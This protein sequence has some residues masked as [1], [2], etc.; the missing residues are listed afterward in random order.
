MGE[1]MAAVPHRPDWASAPPRLFFGAASRH[2]GRMHRLLRARARAAVFLSLVLLGLGACRSGTPGLA[3]ATPVGPAPAAPATAPPPEPAPAPA[4]PLLVAVPAPMPAAQEPAPTE[5][6]APEE[7]PASEPERIQ[8]EALEACQSAEE[9]LGR[10][11]VDAALGAVDR[12]YALMLELPGNHDDTY[13]QAKEDIRVLAASLIDRIYAAGR[14]A[15]VGTARSW[16]LALPIVDNEHVQREL[17]SFTTVERDQFL[18]GYRRSGLY[19]PMILARLEKAGLPAQLSW[20]P[21]VESW[22]KVRALSRAS[23]LGMWQFISST[24]VRYGLDRDTWVDERLDPEKST[25]AAIGYL[26]DLHGLFGD[27]PKA[28][29]AY[30]CGEARVLRLSR[31]S[32]DEYLDFWDLYETLPGETRRYVPRLLAALLIIENP[33]KYGMTLP[34]PD[35]APTN[36]AT[37]RVERSVRLDRLDAALELDAGTLAGLNPALRRQAT[38]KRAYDLR[39]PEGREEALLAQLGSVPEWTPPAPQYATHRVRSG[40]TL[41]QIAGHYGTSVSALMRAN[42]LRSS[43]LRVGQRLRV[44]VRG[45]AAAGGS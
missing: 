5:E 44:P 30:N 43:R 14:H 3:P 29:A 13:L 45:A 38:P 34:E 8:K 12:A 33:A 10:G 42:G 7:E 1:L 19:R 32:T 4:P 41:S 24:G 23:A 27:W 37:V 39:V 21:L 31:Q 26:T 22:F 6:A 25:D 16:D 9:L 36:V 11:D 28:L 2:D 15:P 18:E 35:V 40:E 17:R 20:L